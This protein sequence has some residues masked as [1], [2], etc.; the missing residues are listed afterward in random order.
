MSSVLNNTLGII[1]QAAWPS[2]A[3]PG[4]HGRGQYGS[5]P[6]FASRPRMLPDDTRANFA[7][8]SP[9]AYECP[10]YCKTPALWMT[11]SAHSNSRQVAPPIFDPRTIVPGSQGYPLTTVPHVGSHNGQ[12]SAPRVL[13]A[14]L[15]ARNDL[16]RGPQPAT[17]GG[18]VNN[19]SVVN[20]PNNFDGAYGYTIGGGLSPFPQDRNVQDVY[21][22]PRLSPPRPSIVPTAHSPRT[23]PAPPVTALPTAATTVSPQLSASSIVASMQQSIEFIQD[24]ALKAR[25]EEIHTIMSTAPAV[26]SVVPKVI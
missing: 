22:Q 18:A 2:Y 12:S 25:W 26:R 17:L 14:V 21:N 7:R 20:L 16:R 9:R 23:E 4:L 11:I 8:R 10:T 1:R 5:P 3:P 19:N 6:Q 15:H 13:D 24:L